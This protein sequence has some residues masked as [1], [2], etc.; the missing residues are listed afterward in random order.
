LGFSPCPNDCFIFYALVH[1]KVDGP[2]V[3][4]HLAD[5]EELNQLAVAGRPD[6]TKLSYH[7][8]GHVRDRYSLLAS[9]G[10]LGEGVGP[11]IVTRERLDSLSGRTV[12][13]PGGLTTANLLLKLSQPDDLIYRELRYDLIMPA[14][15]RGEV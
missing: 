1:G 13:I 9:G 6:I 3:A 15:A 11:L 14:V 10:A 7:A 4:P 8:Y 2:A 5:V 12:A